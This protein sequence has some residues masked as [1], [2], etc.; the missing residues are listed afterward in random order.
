M[1]RILDRCS[2]F[3][4][5]HERG[6]GEEGTLLLVIRVVHDG[7]LWRGLA[8]LLFESP[9]LVARKAATALVRRFR[10]ALH[11]SGNIK[12]KDG[13]PLR[14]RQL[15]LSKRGH[16]INLWILPPQVTSVQRTFGGLLVRYEHMWITLQTLSAWIATLGGGYFL[17]RHLSTA[18]QLARQQRSLA[19]FMG[20]YDTADKCTLNEA[21]NYIH[22][23][24]FPLA[25]ILIRQVYHQASTERRQD[26]VTLI[27]MAKA[28]AL[29]LRRVRRT[30]LLERKAKDEV[31]DDYL[32][33][34]IVRKDRSQIDA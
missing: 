21:F 28:A 11:R 20:D 12:V 5:Q 4:L 32:R 27:N 22:A 17:C 33:I 3:E 23:G 8:P 29:F 15:P 6:L 24:M 9:P 2:L 10:K 16:P 19:L 14:C 25:K 30:A 1:I 18:V 31:V 13:S 34:R 7:V 26:A